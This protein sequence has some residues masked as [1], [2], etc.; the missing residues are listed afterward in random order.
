MVL[1][2][3]EESDR[4]DIGAFIAP[5]TG[6]KEVGTPW[7]VPALLGFKTDEH[8]QNPSLK[9][10]KLTLTASSN[11]QFTLNCRGEWH[12]ARCEFGDCVL[13]NITVGFCLELNSLK[14]KDL[15]GRLEVELKSGRLTCNG[16]WQI[17]PCKFSIEID[18]NGAMAD[19]IDK[20]LEVNKK[21]IIFGCPK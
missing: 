8:I 20:M 21:A 12:A 9:I 1:L 16:Q 19:K 6:L 17:T 11:D 10:E 7:L 2:R 18:P 13:D 4:R 15:L 5:A 14:Y 3:P